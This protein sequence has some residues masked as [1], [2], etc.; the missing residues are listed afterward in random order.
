MTPAIFLKRRNHELLRDLDKLAE[1]LTNAQPPV[2]LKSY[3]LRVQQHCQDLRDAVQLNLKYLRI[4]EDSIINDVL[5]R[6]Q[7]ATQEVR[8]LSSMWAI[9]ILR[10]RSADRLCLVT[11]N[12]LHQSHMQ[13]TSYPPVFIS[14]N[15]AIRPFIDFV[16]MYLFPSLEQSRLLYQPLLFHEFGHVLYALH[17]PEMDALMSDLQYAIDDL[18]AP[19][20]Q[21][22][23]RFADAMT[24]RRQT[25]AYTWYRWMQ[26]LFC[27]AVGLS[28]GGPSYL[29]AFSSFLSMRDQGNYYREPRDLAHSSHPVSWLR[30]HFLSRRAATA[31]FVEQSRQIRIE[32]D[33]IAHLMGIAEDYHGYYVESLDQVIT[34][35]I[36][37]MLIEAEPRKCSDLEAAGGGWCPEKDSPVRL[38]NWAWQV[39]QNNFRRYGDWEVEQICKWLGGSE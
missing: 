10:A 38:F 2:E 7:Q 31:G 6:T 3:Q 21:R 34:Q 9:P 13:T 5:S 35:T 39:H 25:I 14:G 1:W 19:L 30:I 8:L 24:A 22:N 11:I 18:L 32:W 37:D 33:G 36:E 27:D 17:R 20:S 23:D 15:C 28:I 4:I 29:Y 16:P 26:E 12:W